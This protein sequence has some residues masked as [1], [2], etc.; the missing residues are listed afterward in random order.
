M[1]FCCFH[2]EVY[3]LLCLVIKSEQKDC[4]VECTNEQWR[5][6]GGVVGV[7]S[8]CLAELG[9]PAPGPAL[10]R[11]SLPSGRALLPFLYLMA[12][13]PGLSHGSWI[14]ASRAAPSYWCHCGEWL[15]PAFG[16]LL[17]DVSLVDLGDSLLFYFE[18]NIFR[19]KSRLF[20]STISQTRFW[21]RSLFRFAKEMVTPPFI[22]A[23][24]K[25]LQGM[26]QGCCAFPGHPACGPGLTAGILH[27]YQLV[28]TLPIFCSI[29]S[30]HEFL[31]FIET[32]K[33]LALHHELRLLMQPWW[34]IEH[35]K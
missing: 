20:D 24:R 26:Q 11:V 23:V 13:R 33:H 35:W 32:A 6:H 31:N 1:Q 21:L 22:S 2:S 19:C 3:F 25:A 18:T 7:A 5:L 8:C 12:S 9:L 4:V 14:S 34:E 15:L 28:G 27:W 29:T 30:L 10:G 16:C 17:L